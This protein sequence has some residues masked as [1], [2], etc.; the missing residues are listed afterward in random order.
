MTPKTLGSAAG[1]AGT[2]YPKPEVWEHTVH[3]LLCFLA[4]EE[5]D[6]VPGIGSAESWGEEG[7]AQIIPCETS[8]P[9]PQDLQSI[10]LPEQ[11]LQSGR[12]YP[13]H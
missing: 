12:P 4:L 13:I 6:N 10:S 3:E 9:V 2:I 7:R 11:P 1:E 5:M 8:P